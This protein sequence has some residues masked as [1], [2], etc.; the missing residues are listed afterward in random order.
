MNSRSV[1]VAA[2][3]TFLY[4]RGRCTNDVVGSSVSVTEMISSPIDD[5]M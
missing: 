3:R 1:L 4:F 2:D 5:P